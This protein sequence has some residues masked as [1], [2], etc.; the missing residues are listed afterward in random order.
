MP[1]YALPRRP[2]PDW[3]LWDGTGW[4]DWFDS[5]DVTV[6]ARKGVGLK[7]VQDD[8]SLHPKIKQKLEMSWSVLKGMGLYSPRT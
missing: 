6:V 5:R 7:Y 2:P 4:A 8:T 1:G 3:D